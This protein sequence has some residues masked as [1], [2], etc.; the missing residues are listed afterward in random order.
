M[1]EKKDATTELAVY[2]GPEY[3]VMKRKPDELRELFEENMEDADEFDLDGV[4]VPGG[5][6]LAWSVPDLNGEPVTTD[7]IVGVV[8]LKGIR[9]GYWEKSFDETG[10]GS[11]PDCKSFDARLGLGYIRGDDRSKEPR[12]RVCDKCP[13]SQ[14]GSKN[15]SDPEDNQQACSKRAL[16][17]LVRQDDVIPQKI[18]L[19]PTSVGPF[20]KFMSRLTQANVRRS[21]AVIGLRLVGDK[22]RTG[23]KY[24]V[25]APRLIATLT[26]EQGACMR[27]LGKALEPHFKKTGIEQRPA[28]V[29]ERERA[30][31]DA[32]AAAAQERDHTRA[33]EEARKATVA[34]GATG[35]PSQEELFETE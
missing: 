4:N 20:K 22:S 6:A 2:D 11:P 24:S 3:A 35:N 33:A 15:P 30:E 25:V 31:R 16:L 23:I 1:P 26:E 12:E 19:A 27:A 13:M 5:G 18:D 9:R 28:D 32:E 7:E 34:E 17:F 8:V 21:E 29:A 14:W 10:G